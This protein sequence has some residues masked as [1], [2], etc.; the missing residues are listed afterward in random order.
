MFIAAEG[1][2]KKAL[3]KKNKNKKLGAKF[4]IK[5]EIKSRWC[6]QVVNR[7]M[8]LYVNV[9]QFISWTAEITSWLSFLNAKH[10]VWGTEVHAYAYEHTYSLE[11]WNNP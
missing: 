3:L 1:N 10:R 9:A 7:N 2:K 6:L 5:E 11:L 4:S 8:K